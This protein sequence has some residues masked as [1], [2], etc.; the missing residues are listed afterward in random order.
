[1]VRLPYWRLSG[2]YFL[3]FGFVGCFTPY[4][5]LYLKAQ[6]FDAWRIGIVMAAMPF[7]RMLAPTLWGWLADRL[8]HKARLVRCA[9]TASAMIFTAFLAA[10]GF[11]AM[12]VVML[13]MSFFWSAAL[14]LMEAITLRH[15][16]HAPER[17]GRV[18][19]WGSVGFIVAVLGTGVA[20]D[21]WPPFAVVWLSLALLGATGLMSFAVP[22]IR[23]GPQHDHGAERLRDALL[24][25]AVMTILLGGML[26][27]VAHAPLYTFLSI[28]LV[29]LGYS[30]A[31]TGAL[32]SLGVCAE[33]VVFAFMPRLL[34]ACSLRALLMACFG[35]AALRFALIGWMAQFAL[36]AVFAQLLHA[37]SFG[38]HHAASMTALNR[39]FAPRR[40]GMVQALF[41]SVSYG[42]G[43]IL[44]GVLSGYGWQHYGAGVTYTGAAVAAAM[45]FMLIAR[46]LRGAA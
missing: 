33:I 6:G 5:G 27:S 13:A 16:S 46:G 29:E 20:L 35:L 8:G 23:L 45:G 42:A 43:G 22:E 30:K 26:M 12:I 37:A 32:W 17:Y 14:P 39:W 24:R 36:V 2:W 28:H 10:D 21:A 7:M 4:F 1:M 15:L 31:Q 19:L 9:M 3:Y 40:Q 34:A 11:A 25:P 18:R 44:G 41:G 38:A